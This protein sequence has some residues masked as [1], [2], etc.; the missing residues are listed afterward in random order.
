MLS[1]AN[2]S[3]IKAP[4]WVVEPGS[5]WARQDLRVRFGVLE[6]PKG[7]TLVDTGYGPR[8]TQGP[9]SFALRAYA[10]AFRPRLVEGPKEVLHRMGYEPDDVKRIIVTHFHAD[11]VAA[12]RDFPKAELLAHGPTAAHVKAARPRQTL[13]H[14]VFTE[15]LPDQLDVTDVTALPKVPAPM[16]L[17]TGYD[18]FGDGQILAIDLPGHAEGHFGLCL[19]DQ[20]LLYACDVQW[21]PG[22]LTSAEPLL[23]RIA[24]HDRAAARQSTARVAAFAEAGG[25]V[26]LCHDPAPCPFDLEQTHG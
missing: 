1:F 4:G 23:G 9:R 8:V 11:H 24:S 10:T 2:S 7:L 19:P 15:L 20:S 25:Q 16:G 14:A 21:T 12:L 17:G 18:L 22:G 26:V 13:R 5:G 6:H 3:F